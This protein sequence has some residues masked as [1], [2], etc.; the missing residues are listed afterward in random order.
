MK[1][2][3]IKNNFMCFGKYSINCCGLNLLIFGTCILTVAIQA[4]IDINN[5][6]LSNKNNEDIIYI[7]LMLGGII[8]IL[9]TLCTIKKIHNNYSIIPD[10]P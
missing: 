3:V 2:N 8:M 1:I 9:C 10:I 4:F 6:K 5:H 7:F